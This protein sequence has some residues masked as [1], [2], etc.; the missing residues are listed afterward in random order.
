MYVNIDADDPSHRLY[1][2]QLRKIIKVSPPEVKVMCQ[3]I[4]F[5]EQPTIANIRCFTDYFGAPSAAIP[6]A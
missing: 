4:G 3:I 2:D 6:S 5:V 1:T